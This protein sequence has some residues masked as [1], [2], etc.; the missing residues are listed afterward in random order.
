MVSQEVVPPEA[1]R[2][3]AETTMRTGKVVVPE[4]GPKLLVPFF[5]RRVM[6]GVSPFAQG[7]LDEA[8]RLAVGAWGI[9]SGEVVVDSQLRA[10]L[11]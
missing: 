7:R 1:A 2:S 8:L 9:G 10:R 4:P 5:R 6:A 11:E 3:A